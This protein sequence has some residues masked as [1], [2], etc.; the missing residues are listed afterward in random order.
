VAISFLRDVVGSIA[1]R[2][3]ADVERKLADASSTYRMYSLVKH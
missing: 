1:A 2:P 3:F